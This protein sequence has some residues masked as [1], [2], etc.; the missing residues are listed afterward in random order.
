[1]MNLEQWYH[2]L[3]KTKDSDLSSSPL[4]ISFTDG[5]VLTGTFYGFTCALDNDPEIASIDFIRND[6]GALTEALEN[7]ITKIE[8][9]NCPELACAVF[10]ATA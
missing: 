1:M 2:E 7:E 3:C 9:L 4:R 6:N 10:E 8:V 5:M